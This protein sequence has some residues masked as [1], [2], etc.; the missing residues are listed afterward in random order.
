MKLKDL[1]E[2]YEPSEVI[3]L[4]EGNEDDEIGYTLGEGTPDELSQYSD[5]I[6]WYIRPALDD[7]IYVFVYPED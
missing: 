6:V 1:F 7:M 2:V 3:S 4:W 5:R